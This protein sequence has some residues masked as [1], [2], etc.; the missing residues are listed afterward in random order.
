MVQILRIGQKENNFAIVSVSIENADNRGSWPHESTL[1]DPSHEST[2]R[3]PSR[4]ESLDEEPVLQ[5]AD[6]KDGAKTIERE[7]AASTSPNIRQGGRCIGW[8]L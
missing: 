4:G 1:R 8:Q 5:S 7:E 3:D 6:F 2:L